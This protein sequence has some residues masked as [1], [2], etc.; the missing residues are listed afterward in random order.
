MR[1]GIGACLFQ[2]GD[3]PRARLAFRRVLQL[4]PGNTAALVGLAVLAMNEPTLTPAHITEALQLLC[5]VT[6]NSRYEQ[7]YK[8]TPSTQCCVIK[9][10]AVTD[11]SVRA[12]R[13]YMRSAFMRFVRWAGFWHD[14]EITPLLQA[15]DADPSSPVVLNML[16]HHSLLRGDADNVVQLAEAALKAAE[17]DAIRC[18]SLT[19]LARARHAR[20]ELNAALR[21]YRQVLTWTLALCF[22]YMSLTQLE[23]HSSWEGV[24]CF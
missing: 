13:L 18:E 3:F 10:D 20:G 14:V 5:Q 16:A 17:S 22:L 11:H 6:F 9:I 19:L 8:R 24:E 1:L 12:R 4:S 2:L 21:G 15:Y 7:V 23:F